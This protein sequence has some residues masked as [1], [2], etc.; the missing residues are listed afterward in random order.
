MEGYG[1]SH[2][3][4]AQEEKTREGEGKEELRER[5]E[6]ARTTTEL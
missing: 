2:K 1:S 5:R 3:E 4:G 6:I